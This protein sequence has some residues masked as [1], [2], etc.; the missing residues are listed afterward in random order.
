[1]KERMQAYLDKAGMSLD[2]PSICEKGPIILEFL[3]HK[4]DAAMQ[5]VLCIK[6]LDSK[7]YCGCGTLM[8]LGIG[9]MQ[10][11]MHLWVLVS[12]LSIN[13]REN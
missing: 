3:S 8:P 12:S 10:H 2:A 11:P 7:P 4:V 6:V 1:M 5:D 9:S 13:F